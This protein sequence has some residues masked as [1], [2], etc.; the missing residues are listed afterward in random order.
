MIALAGAP[1]SAVESAT[2]RRENLAG[3]LTAVRALK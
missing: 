3:L 2:I 1:I